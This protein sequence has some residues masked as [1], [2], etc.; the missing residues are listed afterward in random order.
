MCNSQS[1]KVCQ[2]VKVKV[3]VTLST[4]SQLWQRKTVVIIYCWVYNYERSLCK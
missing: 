1:R 2:G 3:D 4:G